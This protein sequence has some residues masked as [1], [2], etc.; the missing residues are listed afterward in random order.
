M[1]YCQ[2]DAFRKTIEQIKGRVAEVVKVASSADTPQAA[3]CGL[4][5]VVE[6]LGAKVVNVPEEYSRVG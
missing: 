3:A 1:P 4:T 5:S 6:I 2:A